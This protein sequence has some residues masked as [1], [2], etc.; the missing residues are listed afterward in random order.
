MR[1]VLAIA[2]L[3]FAL[4]F[5]SKSYAV[6]FLPDTLDDRVSIQDISQDKVELTTP[7]GFHQDYGEDPINAVADY[8]CSLYK[9][10]AVFLVYW[11][12]HLE[13]DQMGAAAARQ[14]WSCRHHFSF[15]CAIR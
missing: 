15:A 6:E 2:L 14:E 12:N 11:V 5:F 4:I 9:R 7:Y 10:Y 3:S 1:N 13:C 8:A